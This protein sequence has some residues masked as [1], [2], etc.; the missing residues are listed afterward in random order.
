MIGITK[1]YAASYWH[2]DGIP[3][4]VPA[5]VVD[6]EMERTLQKMKREAID[7]IRKEKYREWTK[8]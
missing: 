4:Q 7:Q 8:K 2:H 1:H 6:R 5:W 3:Y